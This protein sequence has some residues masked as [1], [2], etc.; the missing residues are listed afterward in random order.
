TTNRAA[1]GAAFDHIAHQRTGV[2]SL[3]AP[4]P[5]ARQAQAIVVAAEAGWVF[6]Q[7][8]AR[9]L[10]ADRDQWELPHCG[11]RAETRCASTQLNEA[12]DE[13]AWCGLRLCLSL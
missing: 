1:T 12:G 7:R 9:D 13:V 6:K 3:G 8:T 4:S 10:W 2:S 5:E 11:C